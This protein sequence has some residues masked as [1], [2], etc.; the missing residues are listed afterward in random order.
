MP[1]G[2]RQ[3]ISLSSAL[4]VG[5]LAGCI[6]VPNG[7]T[8]SPDTDDA[9]GADD[10]EGE[11]DSDSDRDRDDSSEDSE[12][13][14][15]DPHSATQ[16]LLDFSE[17]K[18][19]SYE[20]A[21]SDY[22]GNLHTVAS[23]LESLSERD[24]SEIT[25][26]D[27]DY[28]ADAAHDAVDTD[29][30]L[31][32]YYDSHPNLSGLADDL[33]SDFQRSF[34][35]SEYEDMEE[36][37]SDYR[38]TYA[39]LS[40]SRGVD[41]RFPNQPMSGDA[42]S[43]FMSSDDP[44][45]DSGYIFEVGY[46]SDSDN[47][48]GAFFTTHEP[49]SISENPFNID[50]DDGDDGVQQDGREL[51]LID[52]VDNLVEKDEYEITRNLYLNIRQQS[53]YDDYPDNYIDSR[54]SV[55]IEDADPIGVAVHELETEDEAEQLYNEY[56]ETGS[57]DSEETIVGHDWER[58]FFSDESPTI[59]THVLHRGNLV[60]LMDVVDIQWEER[61]FGEGEDEEEVSLSE[62]VENTFLKTDTDD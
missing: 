53:L 60:I 33:E 43:L 20:A 4:G 25:Q 28:I 55:S 6:N 58:V 30:G 61:S 23:R 36:V 41:D 10:L 2:R 32:R 21:I 19:N 29:D 50:P 39:Y 44:D 47:L 59:Y 27:V 56:I 37:I 45:D 35:R 9:D 46:R 14:F 5:I 62:V 54:N 15:D 22:R 34:E 13:T 11:G 57:V 38:S 24:M 17:W 52:F 51:K 31:R 40:S 49:V 26:S 3:Y 12:K 48:E 18:L 8:S 7:E 16:L 1:Y 42:Y